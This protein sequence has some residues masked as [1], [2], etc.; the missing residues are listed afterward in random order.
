MTDIALSV[1][2][3]VDWA[4]A[5]ELV[6]ADT[7]QRLTEDLEAALIELRVN[8]DCN[9][10]VLYGSNE[11]GGCLTIPEPGVIQW[12]FPASQMTA[13]FSGNTY[14]FACR[15]TPEGGGASM[16]FAGSLAYL[17]GEF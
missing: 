17:D 7:N 9:H 3:G 13:L 1:T 2:S 16:L 6:D 10:Q 15:I 5:V 14:R 8:D 11:T 4:E 12:L